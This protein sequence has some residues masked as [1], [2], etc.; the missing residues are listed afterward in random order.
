MGKN[1]KNNINYIFIGILVL[2]IIVVFIICGIKY[3]KS[4]K[5]KGYMSQTDS[6]SGGHN[7]ISGSNSF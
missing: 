7:K 4:Y 1:T 6:E 5:R 2:V 3:C